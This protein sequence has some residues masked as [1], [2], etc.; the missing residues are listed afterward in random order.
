MKRKTTEEYKKEL[1]DKR[2]DEYELL[3]EYKNS[4]TKVLIK[5]K[6]CGY[7]WMVNS[8]SI[9]MGYSS[10]PKCSNH[11]ISFNELSQKLKDKNITI[12]DDQEKFKNMNSI[13]HFKCSICGYE[14]KTKVSN[15]IYGKSGCKNCFIKNSRKSPEEFKKEFDEA[16]KKYFNNEYELLTD[17]VNAST[18]IKIKHIPCNTI[19]EKRPFDFL[20]GK[21]CI[22]CCG[23]KKKSTENI[24][25]QLKEVTNGEYELIGEYKNNKTKILVRHNLCGNTFYVTPTNFF[26]C[27]SR[28]PICH[29]SKMQNDIF[30]YIKSLGFNPIENDR[31]EISPLEIDIYVPEKKIGIECNG[32]YWHSEKFVN[33]NYHKEKLDKAKEKGIRLIQIFEDEYYEHRDLVFNKLLHILG[34]D[35]SE[36]VYGRK[37]EVK[38]ISSH[39]KNS[40]LNKYHIQGTDNSSIYLGLFYK[41]ILVAVM[42]FSKPR[43]GIGRKSK[44]ENVYE[45]VRYATNSSYLVIGG[46]GKLL[47]YFNTK[48]NPDEIY[49]YGDLR[50]VDENN[51]IYLKNGF[52]KL[53]INAPNYW[54]CYEKKRF[55]RS[56]FMKNKIREK[57]PQIYNENISEKEMMQNTKYFRVYDCGTVVFSKKVSLS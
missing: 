39:E 2:N 9:L 43:L 8:S 30:N 16:N 34:K 51:N 13:L 45:L 6:L 32:L 36:K 20:K 1:K 12:L 5:H 11:L 29:Q 44:N 56:A 42:T 22:H 46:F 47:K 49:S 41:E 33:K 14:W 52:E 26:S 24:Q 54:Y 28:C 57:L 40:F 10:C 4:S 7:T 53:S 37:C 25:E 23:S 15:I 3:S 38:E 55:H 27:D 19:C 50:W 31:T 21:G 18:K 17:Y 35:S 48:Y